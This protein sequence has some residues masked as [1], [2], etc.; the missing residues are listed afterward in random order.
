MLRVATCVSTG[1][2][3]VQ[4]MRMIS[5]DIERRCE[6][7][8]NPR[9]GFNRQLCPRD[10]SVS[11]PAQ[12]GCCFIELRDSTFELI[13]FE[14]EFYL[15]R[16]FVFSILCGMGLHDCRESGLRRH[17]QFVLVAIV[18]YA[19]EGN[20]LGARKATNILRDTL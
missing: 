2:R 4:S 3:R 13:L 15:F 8:D 20:Y 19:C 16:E 14:A 7:C 9:S 10:T 12:Y 17:R 5:N 6:L 18:E 1:Y 11:D